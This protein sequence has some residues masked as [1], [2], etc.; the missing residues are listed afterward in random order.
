M[1]ENAKTSVRHKFATFAMAAYVYCNNTGFHINATSYET[2]TTLLLPDPEE[3]PFCYFG[4][5]FHR[6]RGKAR[7]LRCRAARAHQ[8]SE[9]AY[10]VADLR[11]FSSRGGL[12]GIARPRYRPLRKR[13][14]WNQRL[15]P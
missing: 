15:P 4:E 11:N 7:Y 12:R 5:F 2:W 14:G 10:Y 3:S 6:A 1:N 8:C 9:R 13:P